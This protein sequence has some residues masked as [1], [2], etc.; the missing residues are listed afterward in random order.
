MWRKCTRKTR[1]ILWSDGKDD[2]KTVAEG[3][4]EDASHNC[5]QPL[6]TT[7]RQE[8]EEE[9]ETLFCELSK[10]QTFWEVF[11][12]TAAFVGK[13]GCYW[14]TCRLGGTLSSSHDNWNHSKESKK[15]DLCI[16]CTYTPANAITKAFTGNQA[17]STPEKCAVASQQNSQCG[18]SPAKVADVCMKNLEQLKFLQQLYEDG[19]LSHAEFIE[20][21]VSYLTYSEN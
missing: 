16:R 3:D 17:S 7:K 15:E 10:G 13:N 21:K 11:S 19:I 9:V 5:K 20:Q 8:K 18:I 12:P 6:E 14:Y 4:H 1:N 2:S